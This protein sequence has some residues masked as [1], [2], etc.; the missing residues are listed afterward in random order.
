MPTLTVMLLGLPSLCL[1]LIL[2]IRFALCVDLMGP[3]AVVHV[4]RKKQ[5]R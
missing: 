2:L 1:V 5:K 3:L 4:T